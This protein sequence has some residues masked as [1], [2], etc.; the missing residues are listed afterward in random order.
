VTLDST[1]AVPAGGWAVIPLNLGGAF[2]NVLYVDDGIEIVSSDSFCQGYLSNKKIKCEKYQA[3][4]DFLAGI[5]TIGKFLLR[6][7]L[8]M[9]EIATMQTKAKSKIKYPLANHVLDCI[10]V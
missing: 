5:Q 7:L 4:L 10:L 2:S 3:R 8:S 6:H 1:L 9:G